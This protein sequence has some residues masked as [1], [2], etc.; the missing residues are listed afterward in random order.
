M[1]QAN[2]R[3]FREMRDSDQLRADMKQSIL[4][5]AKEK[6]GNVYE[7]GQDAF[8]ETGLQGAL[9]DIYRR[10][11]ES[12]FGRDI[13]DGRFQ[14]DTA[15]SNDTQQTLGGPYD[16]RAAFYGLD[17]PQEQSREMDRERDRGEDLER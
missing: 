4:D 9:N 1:D 16:Q 3:I 12:Y 13:F 17:K 7:I 5:R 8:R 15:K 10:C 2:A 14:A 6:L 11:F